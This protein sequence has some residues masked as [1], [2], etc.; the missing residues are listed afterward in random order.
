MRYNCCFV[1]NYAEIVPC[2]AFPDSFDMFGRHTGKYH[3]SP[4]NGMEQPHSVVN[5]PRC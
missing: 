4:C 2:R 3:T 5:T 1:G